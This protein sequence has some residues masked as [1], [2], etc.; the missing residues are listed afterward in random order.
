MIRFILLSESCGF[1][2]VGNPLWREDGFIVYYCCWASP[3]SHSRVRCSRQ[4]RQYFAVSDSILLNLE[5]QIP[6]RLTNLSP[7]VSR[8][9]GFFFRLRDVTIVGS[10]LKLVVCI[11]LPVL[12]Q[13]HSNQ[14]CVRRKP[15]T[16]RRFLLF[17]QSVV[18]RVSSSKYISAWRWSYVATK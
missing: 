2:D 18:S 11:L 6:V 13:V 9:W 3:D 10:Y 16:W 12:G 15:W 14:C 7:S 5:G 1:A 8:S 4:T 17:I